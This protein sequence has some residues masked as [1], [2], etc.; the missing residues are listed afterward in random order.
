MPKVSVII[1]I[2]NVEEYIQ[3]CLE[4][5]VNQTFKDIEILCV[6]DASTDKSVNVVTNYM[7]NDDRIKLIRLS[8]NSGPGVARNT[9]LA[10]SEGEYISFID[11]DDYV[12]RDYIENLYDTALKYDSDMVFTSNIYTVSYIIIKPYYHNRIKKWKIK[13][14]NAW[15]EGISYFNVNTPEKEN[16]PEYPL[17][18]FWNKIYKSD[19]L[20]KNDITISSC[21]IGED[22]EFFYK[23]LAS[24]P[25]ISYNND[26]KY[27]YVQR[28]NSSSDN[29]KNGGVYSNSSLQV[30]KSVFEYY[31]KNRA[32]LLKDCNYYNFKSF[33][34]TFDSYKSSNKSEFYKESH[35][36]MKSLDVE[37]D[38]DKHPF[39]YYALYVMKTNPNY[40]YYVK[41][42]ENMK[43][44]VYSLAWWIPSLN[45]R[46]KFIK[47]MLD[48]KSRKKF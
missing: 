43:K 11:P 24:S 23:V 25:K 13:F 1:P 3:N 6:D 20:K 14:K 8:L 46:E 7:K 27:Y 26:S 35:E 28:K 42:I 36:L 30:F 33:L 19:F 29:V 4:S 39:I 48:S 10:V 2:Y 16:T 12:E 22:V 40:K 37:I 45:F 38:K 15:R 18:T 41:E 34:H 17:V 47:S 31:K 9:A 32:E 44:S 5:I 21:R